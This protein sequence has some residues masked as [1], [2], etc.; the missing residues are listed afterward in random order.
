MSKPKTTHQLRDEELGRH[1]MAAVRTRADAEIFS[2]NVGGIGPTP[3]KFSDDCSVLT[4]TS[5]D[6]AQVRLSYDA[7]LG[8]FQI[9]AITDNSG[10]MALNLYVIPSS[11]NVVAV[12]VV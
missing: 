10:H 4:L 8:A 11:A 12:K 6:G 7:D 3:P 2:V 1:Q 5:K 9:M